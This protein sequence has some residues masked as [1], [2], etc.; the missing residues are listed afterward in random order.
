MKERAN[1]TVL[2]RKS[3]SEKAIEELDQAKGAHEKALG[4]VKADAAIR[5]QALEHQLV[6][7]S[8]ETR[9]AKKRVNE[10]AGALAGWKERCEAGFVQL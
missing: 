7:A 8:N 6:E 10:A 9:D 2:E 1:G 4:G 5:I 3:R